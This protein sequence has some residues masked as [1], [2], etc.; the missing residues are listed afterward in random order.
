MKLSIA[1]LGTLLLLVCLS[2]GCEE[3]PNPLVG[4]ERPFTVYGY[5]DP[6]S[7]RQAIRVLPL[8]DTI[9]SASESIDAQVTSINLT[10]GEERQWKDSLV[11][12]E[13][14]G[15]GHVF[16]SHFTPE[17]G[18]AYRLEIMRSDGVG[19]FVQ[20]TVPPQVTMTG[21]QGVAPVLF[22]YTLQASEKPNIVQA[23]VQY[24]AAALQPLDNPIFYPVDVSYRTKE[25]LVGEGWEITID[26]QDDY[27]VIEEAFDRVC[28]TTEYIR[29]RSMAFVVFIGD[30][31]WVPPGGVFD[32]DVLVQPGLF[33][34]VENGYG[35][36]GAGYTLDANPRPSSQARL[37]A[38]YSEAEPCVDVPLDHPSCEVLPPCFENDPTF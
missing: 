14:G 23:D 35:F 38:G 22:H 20:V 6:L 19:S 12:Y 7:S 10:T 34:N 13:D 26:M 25:E 17:F 16:V 15:T 8:L 36:F 37:A 1:P 32:E 33:S 9:T 3:H 11:T 28:L 24:V 30:D 27:Q 4:E 21:R 5:L 29:M 18:H 31:A 2:A